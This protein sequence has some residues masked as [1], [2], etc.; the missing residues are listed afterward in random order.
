MNKTASVILSK[1]IDIKDKAWVNI[2]VIIH[3]NDLYLWVD[4]KL[5]IAEL[6]ISSMKDWA[7]SVSFGINGWIV[8]FGGF[9]STRLRSLS[10][11]IPSKN[12]KE[13]IDSRDQES[14]VIKQAETLKDKG[15]Q[16]CVK[17]NSPDSRKL[18]CTNEL[19]IEDTVVCVESFCEL[20][21]FM[22]EKGVKAY[23]CNSECIHN[24]AK[25]GITLSAEMTIQ[26]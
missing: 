10:D 24:T 5:S 12:K 26:K 2:R 18:V 15:K 23:E 21:C 3:S 11:F 4:N 13:M 25:A 22:F 1:T 17:A 20:C 14:S 7:G 16:M 8:A 9:I 6:I 19:G